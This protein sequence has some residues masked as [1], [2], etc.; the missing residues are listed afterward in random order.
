VSDSDVSSRSPSRILGAL[1]ALAATGIDAAL[2]AIAL[3]GLA[4][5][6]THRRA[7]ALLGVWLAGAVALA[8]SRPVRA[9]AGTRRTTDPLRMVALLLL[10]MLVAPLAAW[11]ER[12]GVWVLG[13]GL[14]R[15]AAG[16][17]LVAIGL[18][19][20]IAA[21]RQLGS[22]FD[23]TVAILAGHALETRG[24]YARIRHPGYAG[25]LLAALGGAL[26]FA[27][28]LGLPLVALMGLG[29]AGR[30]R[31]EERTLLAHFGGEYAAYRARTGAFLPRWGG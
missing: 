4:D 19:L 11:G 1:G 18:G 20:R 15:A 23:P 16:L 25:A 5:L 7:L 26:V 27:S 3:G 24:P 22:R 29:L 2:L 17:A 8:W 10:P 13:G 28:A 30:I 21:M 9:R 14:P 6:A 31:D 12:H